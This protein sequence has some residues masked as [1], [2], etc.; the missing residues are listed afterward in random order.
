[1]PG[2]FA[3]YNGKPTLLGRSSRV[4]QSKEPGRYFEVDCNIR[5]W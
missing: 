5:Y 3:K 1:M 2:M 4:A